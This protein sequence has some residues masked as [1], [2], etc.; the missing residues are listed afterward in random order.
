MSDFPRDPVTGETLDCP[1]FDAERCQVDADCDEGWECRDGTCYEVVDPPPE[2]EPEPRPDRARLAGKS[3]TFVD[4][5]NFQVVP[6]DVLEER[7]PSFQ[8]LTPYKQ[9]REGGPAWIDYF[10]GDPSG[11]DRFRFLTNNFWTDIRPGNEEPGFLYAGDFPF[12]RS[13]VVN[14][15]IPLRAP[16]ARDIE[17]NFS[18]FYE[19]DL[20]TAR[21]E[22]IKVGPNN[23]QDLFNNST[24]NWRAF[25]G[26]EAA[27]GFSP[28]FEKTNSDVK[29]FE[30]HSFKINVPFSSREL[31]RLGAINRPSVERHAAEYNF[32]VESYEAALFERVFFLTT[33]IPNLYVFL[34]EKNSKRL[35]GEYINGVW[36][37]SQESASIYDKHITING[38]LDKVFMDVLN[39]RGEKIG[40]KD[41][42]QYFEK[43]AV[44]R[45][46]AW[47][48]DE[49]RARAL[50]NKFRNMIFSPEEMDLFK[51]YNEKR[52][53][54]PMHVDLEFT[55]D[56]MTEVAEA[57]KAA[58]LSTSII[59]GW[60]ESQEVG[61]QDEEGKR[62][63]F[64]TPW[65]SR[66][67]DFV[68]NTETVLQ[69]TSDM[70]RAN[71]RNI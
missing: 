4:S 58:G 30:D 39:E 70:R 64:E 33:L 69:T 49:P 45:N 41:E 65:I 12:P 28:I 10:K 48:T 17:T 24:D 55:T 16:T 71:I 40:E 47:G 3:R 67:L 7:G 22:R 66:K 54:F 51:A 46:S 29:G 8:W 14:P 61:I 27:G 19:V 11:K 50:A 37:R 43:W 52:F 68:V 36:E 44:A 1:P 59:R 25:I 56:T 53:M 13:I 31:K 62:F 60:L 32:F 15:Y 26:E 9:E 6:V 20:E 18:T 34:A 23:F 63:E 21:R 42:G 57:V 35:S 2:P 5:A 38:Y